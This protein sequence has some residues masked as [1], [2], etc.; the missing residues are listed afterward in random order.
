MQELG[1]SRAREPKLTNGNMYRRRHVQ[2]IKGDSPESKSLF[3]F[4]LSLFGEFESSRLGVQTSLGVQYF[5]AV[6]RNS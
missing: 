6:L 3:F 4:P 1:G 5:S 2:F